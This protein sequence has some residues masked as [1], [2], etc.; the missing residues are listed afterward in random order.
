MFDYMFSFEIYKQPTGVLKYDMLQDIIPSLKGTL[1]G[2]E[3]Y[4]FKKNCT[5]G[6]F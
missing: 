3:L 2:T 6:K 4:F 5:K 1:Q